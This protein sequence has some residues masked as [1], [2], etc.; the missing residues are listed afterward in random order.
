ML[1]QG[2]LYGV[3]R[4]SPQEIPAKVMLARFCLLCA[5]LVGAL[6]S[7]GPGSTHGGEC[8][9]D[10]YRG[11]NATLLRDHALQLLRREPLI[12]THM[13][14]PQILRELCKRDGRASLKFRSDQSAT[15]D[16]CHRVPGRASPR[17]C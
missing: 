2:V 3:G 6:A 1:V 17:S 15:T 7:L 10:A 16:R 9:A 4:N 14:M 13:D 12:D 11:A 8:G 5:L